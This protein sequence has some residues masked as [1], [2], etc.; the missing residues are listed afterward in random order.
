LANITR[1]LVARSYGDAQI[2][3]IL[4]ENA[5]RIFAEVCG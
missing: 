4:G 5:H 2:R 3:G 1:G